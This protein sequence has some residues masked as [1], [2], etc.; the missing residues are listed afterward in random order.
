MNTFRPP[1]ATRLTYAFVGAILGMLA[2]AAAF[3]L[4]LPLGRPLRAAG[5]PDL[6][7]NAGRVLFLM[8]LAGAAA[9]GASRAYRLRVTVTDRAVTVH[10]WVRT[11]RIPREDVIGVDPAIFVPVLRWRS[12]SG[13]S[14]RTLLTPFNRGRGI[15]GDQRFDGIIRRLAAAL[16]PPRR[17]VRRRAARA[18][19]GGDAGTGPP[20]RSRRP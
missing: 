2:L 17:P 11:R 10:G 6:S 18:P 15:P 12:P 7:L 8:A 20:T 19:A 9:A 16:R 1:L 3:V 4:A 14:R 13:Q 5:A